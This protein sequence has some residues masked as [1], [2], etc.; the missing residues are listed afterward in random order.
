MNVK[1]ES[2]KKNAMK[3]IIIFL[4]MT[5]IILGI[6]KFVLDTSVFND[7][8]IQNRMSSMLPTSVTV[9]NALY[10]KTYS[11][12]KYLAYIEVGEYE[13]AYNMFTDE[14][15]AYKSYKDYMSDIKD[16]DFTTFRVQE[17]K[18][19]TENTFI[20]PV[21]YMQNG[22]LLEETYLVLVNK[23]NDKIM[24]ISPDRFLYS[25]ED[26]LEFSKNHI[27]FIIEEETVYSDKIH[28]KV[29]VKNNNLFEDINITKIGIG[30]NLQESKMETVNAK[31]EAK[32]SQTFEIEFSA[33]YDVPKYLKIEREMK[34]VTRTYTFEL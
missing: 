23:V 22:E 11:I 12:A 15:K 19:L 26:K 5:C 1:K 14:Y 3:K 32:S 9:E 6:I 20:V 25:L 16:I 34:E 24:K 18:E 31:I 33:N 10:V 17:V 30:Y 7:I 27:K 28:L 29:T 21:E 13:K 8:E 2:M 4:A